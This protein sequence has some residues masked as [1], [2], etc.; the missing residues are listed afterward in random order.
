MKFNKSN[1]LRKI[2]HKLIP[3]GSHTYSKGDDQ[4]PAM[5][6]G[7][8]VKGKGAYVWDV[9]GNKFLDWGMGLRSVILGHAYVPVINVV[10]K[11]LDFGV[12]FSK[13]S[14]LEIKLAEKIC[15][16]IPS[17]EMVKFNKNG[18]A[19][20]SAAVK[21]ARA[22][23]KRDVIA[24]PAGSYNGSDDWG[25]ATT[26]IDSGIPNSVKK[27]TVTFE[28]NNIESV[29]NLFKKYPNKIACFIL[30]P[31]SEVEP[32]DNF[33]QNLQRLCKKNGTV[34]IFDEM[35]TGF[36]WHLKGAQYVYGVTPDLSTFGKAMANGFS[37]AVLVGKRE[38]MQLGGMHGK[39][40]RVFL[41]S[42]THGAETHALAAT[43]KTIDEIKNKNVC[44][45]I[46]FIGKKIKKYIN[47][48]I[49]NNNL[50]N[51]I[52]IFGVHG[53]RMAMSVMPT[54]GYTALEIKTYFLQELIQQGILFNG[55][56][57][58][59]FSHTDVE[60]NKTVKAWNIACKK[61][62]LALK[63]KNLEKMLIG[64]PIRPVFR[65]FN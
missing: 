11:Q 34:L 53:S 13:P 31:A 15:Q 22:Y 61:L 50:E 26:A 4:F 24:M 12:N 38:I 2:S 49:K 43:I 41:L 14:V 25:M 56:F 17:A 29:Q 19:A 36:R 60:V 58:P 52:N 10:K 65:K 3:G 5:S 63:Q 27:M 64:T 62:K 21:L 42:S 59:S 51:I 8:I 57:A 9:D 6:P 37:L 55:Y 20:T 46:N 47:N 23:T 30:E 33:L 40:E 16:I 7:F 48:I 28:Y 1:E 44:S 39:H 45:H 32:K 35:I 18:S 54:E